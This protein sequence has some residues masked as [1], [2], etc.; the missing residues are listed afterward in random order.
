MTTE[1]QRQAL[2]SKVSDPYTL[3]E[4]TIKAFRSARTTPAQEARRWFRLALSIGEAYRAGRLS[5]RE[6]DNLR[7]KLP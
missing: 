5:D 2:L 4:K 7:S 6:Y 3:F 1:A